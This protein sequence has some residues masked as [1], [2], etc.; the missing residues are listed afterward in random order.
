MSEQTLST[1]VVIDYQNVHLTA[2]DV[3]DKDG[4]KHNSLIHPRRFAE[5]AVRMRNQLQ[6]DGYPHAVLREVVAFRGM[7]HS[8]YDWEQNRRCNA[9]AS[10]WRRDGATGELRDLRQHRFAGGSIRPSGRRRVWNTNLD[11]DCYEAALDPHDYA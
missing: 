8:L 4:E 7:P 6:R 5:T 9:Q 1:V 11:R 10:Q 2:R 3:F